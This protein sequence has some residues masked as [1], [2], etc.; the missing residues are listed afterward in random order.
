MF[1]I[2]IVCMYSS[3]TD[4]VSTYLLY[5]FFVI[6]LLYIL[7]IYILLIFFSFFFPGEHPT[8]ILL[9][10]LSLIYEHNWDGNLACWGKWSLSKMQ[11]DCLLSTAIPILLVAVIKQ[12][13]KLL[14]RQCERTACRRI[15]ALHGA[16]ILPAAI[17]FGFK[18]SCSPPNIVRFPHALREIFVRLPQSLGFTIFRI[19]APISASCWRISCPLQAYEDFSSVPAGQRISILLSFFCL[20]PFFASFPADFLGKP[21]EK[22]ANNDHNDCRSLGNW[23]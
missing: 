21:A 22:I 23:S 7:P 12:F 13:P 15:S 5:S 6:L 1:S 18:C 11:H 16:E 20:Q 19:S 14:S 2:Q 8:H 4:T 9:P 17:P 10:P 3:F